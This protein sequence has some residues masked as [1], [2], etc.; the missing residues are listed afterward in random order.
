[1]INLKDD[2]VIQYTLPPKPEKARLA[3]QTDTGNDD[4]WNQVSSHVKLYQPILTTAK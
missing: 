3:I 1:M 2:F 4:A